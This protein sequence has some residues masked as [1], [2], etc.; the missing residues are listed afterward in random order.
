MARWAFWLLIATVAG[1]L[2][3]IGTLY[4]TR[5]AAQAAVDMMNQARDASERQL[6]AYLYVAQ[7]EITITRHLDTV[8]LRI[9]ISFVNGGQTPAT[10]LSVIY[11]TDLITAL[12]E[13][14]G[15]T[16]LL[17]AG[18]HHILNVGPS[19]TRNLDYEMSVDAGDFRRP[20]EPVPWLYEPLIK[21]S[22]SIAYL[23]YTGRRSVEP[24][25]MTTGIIDIPPYGA[26]PRR[27]PFARTDSPRR[28]TEDKYGVFEYH[29]PPDEPPTP[30]VRQS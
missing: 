26:I 17:L 18:N 12:R 27:I 4:E 7:G 1:V 21:V 10:N 20:T 29:P 9:I 24:F 11:R 25:I 23:D 6:R 8:G 13:E 30:P 3:L 22:G 5:K 2:L 16:M 19:G 14:E 28:G 15:N